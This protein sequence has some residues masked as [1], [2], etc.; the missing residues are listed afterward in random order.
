MDNT[1]TIN[2]VLVKLH[3]ILNNVG[4]MLNENTQNINTTLN[5]L[6]NVVETFGEV[7]ENMKDVTEVVTE[8]TADFLVTKDSVKSNMDVIVD[9]LTIIKNIF[10]DKK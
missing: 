5:N 4:T 6:P 3:K 2:I 10:V 9:I 7:G 8:V 1:I